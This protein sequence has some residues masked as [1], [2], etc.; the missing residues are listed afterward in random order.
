[1][2]IHSISSGENLRV[3]LAG[4]FRAAALLDLIRAADLQ[5]RMV[6]DARFQRSSDRDLPVHQLVFPELV[7]AYTASAR[8]ALDSN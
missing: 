6:A 5:T 2:M 4:S 8:A 7:R 1:M 3:E